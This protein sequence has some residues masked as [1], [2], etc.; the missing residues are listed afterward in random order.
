MARTSETL[1]ATQAAGRKP[2]LPVAS[3]PFVS[4]AVACAAVVVWAFPGATEALIDRHDAP[5][6]SGPWRVLTGSLV[7]ASWTHLAANVLLFLPL[8]AWRERQVGALRLAAELAAL[9]LG[10]AV[11]VRWAHEG[12]QTYCGLSG[13][14]YGLVAAIV[15]EAALRREPRAA[16]RG[17]SALLLCAIF[18]KTGLEVWGGG[19]LWASDALG[20]SLGVRYLPGSHLGGLASGALVG[21]LPPAVLGPS[22]DRALAHPARNS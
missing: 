2:W 15:L 18:V 21:L 17:A 11:G 12:W 7:H 19:W 5:E 9:A 16:L 10:V 20:R 6:I 8:A 4:T 14:V 1:R 13:V 22:G 3:A